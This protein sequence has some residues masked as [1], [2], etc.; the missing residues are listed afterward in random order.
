MPASEFRSF[1]GEFLLFHLE[2]AKARDVDAEGISTE[3]GLATHVFEHIEKT[4]FSSWMNGRNTPSRKY[5]RIAAKYIYE[6]QPIHATFEVFWDDFSKSLRYLARKDKGTTRSS[7]AI[8]NLAGLYLDHIGERLEQQ[9]PEVTRLGDLL[10]ALGSYPN[11]QSLAIAAPRA[12]QLVDED[13]P[14]ISS[15]LHWRAG[16]TSIKG[17]EEQAEKLWQWATEKNANWVEIAIVSGPGGVGKSRL[18]VEVALRLAAERNWQSGFVRLGEIREHIVYGGACDGLFVIVDYPEERFEDISKVILEAQNTI[19]CARPIRVVITSREDPSKWTERLN[20]VDLRHTLSL[21]LA[22]CPG[23]SVPNATDLVIQA[24]NSFSD[25]AGRNCPDLEAVQNWVLKSEHNR[26]PLLSIA[27]AIHAVLEPDKGFLLSNKEVLEALVNIEKR[28]VRSYSKRDVG[29]THALEKLMALSLL[30]DQ[31]LFRTTIDQLDLEKISYGHSAVPLKNRVDKTPYW[32]DSSVSSEGCL[33]KIEPDIFGV[34]FFVSV[35]RPTLGEYETLKHMGISASQNSSG[36]L[37]ILTRILEDLNSLDHA[38]YLEFRS[39]IL[40]MIDFIDVTKIEQLDPNLNFCPPS[41]AE[42]A[43]R[44]LRKTLGSKR[45]PGYDADALVSLSNVLYC[46]N[47]TEESIQGLLKAR[48]IYKQFF[49]QNPEQYAHSFAICSNNLAVRHHSRGE[50]ELAR[51]YISEAVDIRK[52][53]VAINPEKYGALCKRSAILK[54]EFFGN[55]SIEV[56]NF[57]VDVSNLSDSDLV[58]QYLVES[59][60]ALRKARE[61]DHEANQLLLVPLEFFQSDAISGNERYLEATG[62]FFSAAA[63]VSFLLGDFDEGTKR[64][65]KSVE[66]FE[67]LAKQM[68]MEF[69]KGLSSH[70]FQFADWLAKAGPSRAEFDVR[71]LGVNT[72]RRLSVSGEGEALT[73]LASALRSLQICSNALALELG[74]KQ[75]LDAQLVYADEATEIDFD[76]RNAPSEAFVAVMSRG[77]SVPRCIISYYETENSVVDRAELALREIMSAEKSVPSLYKSWATLRLRHYLAAC[78]K[79][80]RPVDGKLLSEV[81][82][83]I[84]AEDRS[85]WRRI[86]S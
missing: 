85:L 21:P 83:F 68:P 75:D 2:N 79:F 8:P 76:V 72:L 52:E 69:G 18:V 26:I 82:T 47:E 6:H 63:G 31:G 38:S 43:S 32:K 49:D 55:D 10:L 35:L 42:F 13:G 77:D 9:Q 81:Q 1:Q 84:D 74:A 71:Q 80:D 44:F 65:R 23:L 39:A 17:R 64:Y 54:K 41:M 28:R 30:S 5:Q 61:G 34:A 27:A 3:E 66:N 37:S 60:I 86:F 62:I 73:Q 70:Y 78:Q 29:D 40:T 45:H 56:P 4:R 12:E 58:N 15:A 7:E 53:L 19:H 67:V 50:F 22:S 51:R 59:S 33:A 25:R 57:E 36:L 48:E 20:L 14:R 11:A 16:L 46:V 24:A